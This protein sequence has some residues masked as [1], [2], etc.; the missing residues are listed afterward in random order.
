MR[1]TFD[2]KKEVWKK[3]SKEKQR[4]KHMQRDKI[5]RISIQLN[6]V[7]EEIRFE[8]RKKK[9]LVS[10]FILHHCPFLLFLELI[11]LI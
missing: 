3:K 9:G 4:E 11:F 5:E 10:M 6:E 1:S 7:C 2:F 8:K